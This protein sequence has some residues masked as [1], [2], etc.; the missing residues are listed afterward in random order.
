MILTP[1]SFLIVCPM[2]FLAGLLGE[3]ISRSAPERNHYNIKE[4]I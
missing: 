2:L 1:V 3:M 4:E